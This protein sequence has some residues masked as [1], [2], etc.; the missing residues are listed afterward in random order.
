MSYV[1]ADC[2]NFYVSCERLFN[3]KLEG[4][5]VVVLSSNDGC[6][7]ARS[8]EAKA[9][10]FQMGEPYFKI[11]DFCERHGVVVFS[12]NYELYGDISQRIMQV[13]GE[14][15]PEIE[16]YSIDEAFLKYPSHITAEELY[17]TCLQLRRMVKKWVGIPV[18]FGIAPTKTLAKV[19][20]NMAK[21]DRELGI[22]DLSD[23][24]K[25]R[26]I[27]EEYEVGK[28]WGIGRK[29]KERL[30]R[31]GIH[32]ALQFS[33][34]DPVLVR[35]QMGVVGERMLWEL[36]GVSCLDLDKI[37]PKKSITCSRSFGRIVTEFSELAEALSTFVNSACIRMREQES[38]ASALSVY[39]ES[40]LDSHEGTRRYFSLLTSFDIPTCDTPQMITAAKGCLKRLYSESERYKKCG[41]ILL[42]LIPENAVMSDLFLGAPDPKRRTMIHTVDALNAR[43]GKNTLFY[44]AMGVNHSWRVRCDRASRH[45]TTDWADLAIAQAY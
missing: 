3:P 5:P 24:E 2:N 31:I 21:K 40:I 42:D 26:R 11:R 7:V 19:A 27:L 43:F 39:L 35:R 16:I 30:S 25:Q 8:Q 10:G 41:V 34:L 45:Y 9:L 18:S 6:I 28:V 20:N 44:G 29:L 32:T 23:L 37:A 36:R 13:L 14:M 22:F 1:L 4:I 38:C 15:A 33:D 12:S 17:A